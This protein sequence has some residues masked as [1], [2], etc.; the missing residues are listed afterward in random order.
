MTEI[1]LKWCKEPNK[2]F[3]IEVKL[4]FQLNL[5]TFVYVAQKANLALLI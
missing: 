1:I 3:V 2:L 4:D 5:N